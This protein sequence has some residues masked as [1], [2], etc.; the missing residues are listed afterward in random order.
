MNHTAYKYDIPVVNRYV[1]TSMGKKRIEKV[2]EFSGIGLKD[3]FNLGFG[4]LLPD[5]TIDDL[6][7]SNN[8]DIV[9]VLVT[10]IGIIRDFTTKNPHAHIIFT[11]ST[12]ER[13]ELY[14]RI[15]RS[16]YSS[17]IEEFSIS[18]FVKV[19]D[20]YK[21]I[22]FDPDMDLDFPFYLIKRIL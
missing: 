13:T 16:Y 3:T 20:S 17:F 11:G 18:G 5:G 21:V 12:K 1:F 4:D 7:N 10:V 9:K 8:G 2:V 15:L 14:S 22:P 19:G 6:A